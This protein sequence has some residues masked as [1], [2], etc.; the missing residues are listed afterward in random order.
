MRDGKTYPVEPSA[1]SA[2]LFP[3]PEPFLLSSLG[4]RFLSDAITPGA[5][6]DEPP[7]G[8]SPLCFI[9]GLPRFSSELVVIIHYSRAAL[10][11]LNET[12]LSLSMFAIGKRQVW[13]ICPT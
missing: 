10:I 2:E 9:A 4:V 5:R 12:F 7:G 11:Q 6:D 3:F 8:D 13:T 1:F